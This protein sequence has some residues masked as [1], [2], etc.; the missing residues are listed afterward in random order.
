MGWAWICGDRWVMGA[1][2]LGWGAGKLVGLCNGRS[3]SWPKRV[4]AAAENMSI[5]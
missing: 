1:G 4:T 3:G 2:K 5:G